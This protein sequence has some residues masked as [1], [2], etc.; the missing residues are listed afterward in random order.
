MILTRRGS[1][2][3]PL[4]LLLAAPLIAAVPG[5]WRFLGPDGGSVYDLA[6][7]PSRPQALYAATAGGVFRSLD[8]GASWSESSFGL[9]PVALVS[10]LAVDPV[11]PLTVYALQDGVV[12]RSRDGG[13][14]WL[15][16]S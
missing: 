13:A 3:F 4:L 15:P 12:F 8:G 16:V 11:H 6:F 10:S 5:S 14:A 2:L 9:D 1:L 7:A